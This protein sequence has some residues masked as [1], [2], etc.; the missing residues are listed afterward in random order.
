MPNQRR[1]AELVPEQVD[2]YQ[3]NAKQSKAKQ[4]QQKAHSGKESQKCKQGLLLAAE[5][6]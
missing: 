5:V 6:K 2:Y 4:S 1:A 3:E